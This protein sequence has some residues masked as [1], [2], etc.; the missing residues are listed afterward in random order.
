MT[1]KTRSARAQ[2][3]LRLDIRSWCALVALGVCASASLVLAQSDEADRVKESAT[4]LTEIMNAPDQAIPTSVLEK[5]VGIAVFPGTVRGGFIVGAERGR[6]ILS[7]RDEKTHEWSAPAFLTITGGSLGLQIGLRATD[8]ILVIQNRRGLENLVR[9]EFKVG[10]G[11]AVTGGPV[12]RDAQASTDIQLRAEILSYSRSRGLFAGATIE[13]STIK[14]DQ[15]ANGRYY[16]SRMTTRNIVFDG[17]A[18]APETL[19]A[20]TNALTKFA[21]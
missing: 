15:D 8:L 9:N 20:W 3:R 2:A 17:K 11:A 21:K 6:G 4:V 10:A 14:E 1:L 7:V 18:K 19:A 12:G 13:G 16:G 5:A